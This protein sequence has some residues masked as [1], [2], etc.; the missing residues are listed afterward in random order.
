MKAGN[1]AHPE[2]DVESQRVSAMQNLE[3]AVVGATGAVGEE[4]IEVCEKLR[5]SMLLKIPFWSMLQ[6][7]GENFKTKQNQ[8]RCKVEKEWT[9]VLFIYMVPAVT[10]PESKHFQKDFLMACLMPG[11]PCEEVPSIRVAWLGKWKS[12]F[13]F[14][15]RFLSGFESGEWRLVLLA[16]ERSAGKSMSTPFGEKQAGLGEGLIS[17]GPTENMSTK[18]HWILIWCEQTTPFGQERFVCVG[19]GL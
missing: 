11:A 19:G 17:Q 10:K 6:I 14:H 3:V 5:F 9:N 8:V 13:R 7:S 2:K 1:W 4:M 18:T 16:S 15:A 12:R